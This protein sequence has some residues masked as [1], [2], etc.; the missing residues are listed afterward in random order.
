MVNK[1]RNCTIVNIKIFLV[2]LTISF[3][4]IPLV[5]GSI[6]FN[7]NTLIYDPL[8]KTG[9]F[10]KDDYNAILTEEKHA[11][12]N[13]T[14]ND[15]DL[16][17]LEMGFYIYNETYPQIWEDYNSSILNITQIDMQFV[18]TMDPAIVD[19]LK[20]SIEDRNI[21]TVKL[22]ESIFVE[23]NNLTQGY[24][25]YHAR[26][27]PCDL[28][29]FFVDNNTEVFELINETDYIIDEDGFIVFNYDNYFQKGPTLNFS[30][31]LIWEYDINI[32]YWSLAQYIGTNLIMNETE[33]NF[34][35]KY[36]YN[37]TLI[38]KKFGQTINIKNRYVDNIDLALTVNLPDKSSLNNHNLELNGEIVNIND[39]LN[40]TDKAIDIFLTDYFNANQS[41][42]S[43]N[44]TSSFTLKFVDPV[45]DTWAIDRLVAE[46]NIRER[47][48]FPSLLNGPQHI[49]LKHISFYEP[50]IY[51]DQLIK[52]RF[53]QLISNY[54]LFERNTALFELNTS[55]TGK[56]GI[57][58]KVPYLIVGETC[59]FIIKYK[60]TQNL[61]IIITDNIKMPLVG[62]S[63]EVFYFG[64][65]FG[66][67]ISNDQ[68]QPIPPGITNEHGE[69]VLKNVP[70]GNY[71]IRV[72]YNAK[73]IIESTVSTYNEINY[74]YTNVPHVPLWILI[75]GIINGTIL[76][77]GVA[78]YLKYKKTR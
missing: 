39:H 63:V 38:G 45:G 55:L 34:T 18:E 78:F 50:T 10:S 64:Q 60:A 23:Y 20:E 41:K 58:V 42:F 8:P 59:P 14:I 68:I 25:I 35:A 76:I 49:Y 47:I 32:E 7:P 5:L 44:F 37:F 21:I 33:Q 27:Y 13:I 65:K 72:Y 16:S 74:I 3:I 22:N 12:G 77:I 48:Y 46:R 26:L 15:I 30:M 11:L 51:F 53:D 2:L 31:Y 71:T 6:R 4:L 61:R 52:D 69:I 1:K 43:L 9:D 75:F 57:Q 36:S 24:L 73:F 40:D 54:S 62:A 56:E 19:N 28:L 17:E 29:Q 66:T 67:Y 70:H